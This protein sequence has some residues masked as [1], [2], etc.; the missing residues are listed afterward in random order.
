VLAEGMTSRLRG[1]AAELGASGLTAHVHVRH[2]TPAAVILAEAERQ[3]SRL[4]VMTT[5]GQGGLTRWLVGSVAEKGMQL[6]RCPVLLVKPDPAPLSRAQSWQPH[7]LL[8]PLDGSAFADQALPV[9][10]R[11][12]AALGAEVVLASVQPW[13]VTRFAAYDGY[14]PDV[15]ALDEEA[16]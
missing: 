16:A 7:R 3:R 8:A 6:A 10:Y 2:G 12:A 4:I 5:R 15:A 11:W 13:M 14:M 9:A 1:I